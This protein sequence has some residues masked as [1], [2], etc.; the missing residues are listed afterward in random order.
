VTRIGTN[1]LTGIDRLLQFN[2]Q[3]SFAKQNQAA[4]RLA[5]LHRIN[6]AKDDPAGLIAVESLRSELVAL[7]AADRSASRAGAALAVADSGLSQVS[8]RLIEIKGLLV[9]SAGGTLSD[10]QL[11]ANQAQIDAN[12]EAINRV[13]NTTSFSGRNLLDGETFDFNLSA[14]PSDIVSFESANIDSANLGS[15]EG[16]L[17]D[18]G[19][20]GAASISS[21]N[22][23]EAAEILDIVQSQVTTARASAGTFE[24]TIIRSSQEISRAAQ[25]NISGAIS[26][27]A[28]A[29]VAIES[30]KLIQAQILVQAGLKTL[31]VGNFNRGLIT[32]LFDTF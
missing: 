17:S 15:A 3:K 22:F 25:I 5:T 20:G 24:K 18:L 2:L 27:I 14:N 30:A 4:T 28:D 26:Q 19:S 8:D 11:A 7:E 31:Q 12:I 6:Q 16:R 29:D 10:A 23:I 9:E 13:G 32:G 1:G 21:G